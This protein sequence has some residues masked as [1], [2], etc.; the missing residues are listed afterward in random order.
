MGFDRSPSIDSTR[1]REGFLLRLAY[2]GQDGGQA[3]D[4]EK[5]RG[6]RP[7]PPPASAGLV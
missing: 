5:R 4:G 1:P 6:G 2:G 3:G 7:A